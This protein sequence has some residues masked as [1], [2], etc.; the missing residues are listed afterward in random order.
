MQGRRGPKPV[1]AI[2]L[3]RERD[4]HDLFGVRGG[5]ERAFDD[6]LAVFDAHGER[7]IAGELEREDVIE[8]GGF[9]A[10][11]AFELRGGVRRI[12]DRHPGGDAFAT[13]ALE[14][15]HE[16]PDISGDRGSGRRG[17]IFVGDVDGVDPV[18]P[19]I[20][21]QGKRKTGFS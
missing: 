12:G 20:P 15:A 17:H 11:G 6:L 7:A 16:H 2:R 3:L 18:D 5:F 8:V 14:H 4:G 13:V 10:A 1:R 19:P 9:V 21:D